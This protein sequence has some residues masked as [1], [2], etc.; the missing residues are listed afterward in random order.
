MQN[1]SQFQGTAWKDLL[2]S[3]QGEVAN[4]DEPFGLEGSNH[5]SQ[6]PVAGSKQGGSFRGRQFIR[7]AI[8]A[9]TFQERQRAVVQHDMLCE[10]TL[11]CPKPRRKQAP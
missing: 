7:G 5:L 6:V 2:R 10:E 3:L 1:P 4:A 8:A 9:A 11:R